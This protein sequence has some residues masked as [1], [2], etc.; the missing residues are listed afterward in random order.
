[1][2]LL[3][4]ATEEYSGKGTVIHLL[5]GGT[6]SPGALASNGTQNQL[7][8]QGSKVRRPSQIPVQLLAAPDWECFWTGLQGLCPAMK[9]QLTN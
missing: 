3:L 2:L 6:T 5:L 1:M 8:M 9:C 4:F 7:T